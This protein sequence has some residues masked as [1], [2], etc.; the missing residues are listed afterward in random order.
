MVYSPEIQVK[1]ADIRNHL[2]DEDWLCAFDRERLE[3]L[4]G[5]M[6]IHGKLR[7]NAY[8]DVFAQTGG[9]SSTLPDSYSGSSFGKLGFARTWAAA[10]RSIYLRWIHSSQ[11]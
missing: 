8:P 4:R 9:D 10:C 1:M 6:R 5:E 11:S 3:F 2:D 7:P